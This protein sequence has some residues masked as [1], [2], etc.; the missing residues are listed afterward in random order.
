M[1][2]DISVAQAVFEL[3]PDYVVSLIE[4]SGLPSGPSDDQ[5]REQLELAV[6]HAMADGGD[7]HPHILAW[8][9]AFRGFGVRPKRTPPSADAL[10]QRL[11]RG[12]PAINRVVDIYNAVSVEHA[13]PVGGEDM[14]RYVGSA[15]LVL[16]TGEESFDIFSEGR[17]V[18]D[19]PLPGEV[20]WRDDEGVTCRRWNW[21]Q[22]VRTRITEESSRG[23]FLLERLEPLQ[24]TALESAAADLIERLCKLAPAATVR[25]RTITNSR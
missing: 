11:D 7:Q 22:C 13:I 3:R 2:D 1:L 25:E 24:V 18:N 23:Y 16:A 4:I 19:P 12:L 15:R 9:D 21:R 17:L 8:R 10:R 6:Q 14:D 20:V 5:S